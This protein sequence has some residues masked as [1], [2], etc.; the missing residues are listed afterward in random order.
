MTEVEIYRH[1]FDVL[2]SHSFVTDQNE[3]DELTKM[4]L[5]VIQ[6]SLEGLLTE[7][8]NKNATSI[9]ALIKNINNSKPV[10]TDED[11]I[12]ETN[13]LLEDLVYQS[14]RKEYLLS[15]LISKTDEVPFLDDERCHICSDGDYEDNDLIVFCDVYF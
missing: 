1:S 5:S 2:V 11:E 8:S 3:Y 10:L 15:Q 9:L 13:D 6:S 7:V 4:P 12:E 14:E